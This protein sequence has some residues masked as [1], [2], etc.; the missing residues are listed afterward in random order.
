MNPSNCIQDTRHK[1]QVS[2]R[3]CATD[4]RPGQGMGGFPTARTSLVRS[5]QLSWR[6]EEH[7]ILPCAWDT[8]CGPRKFG[9]AGLI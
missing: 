5:G 1:T 2:R 6:L 4:S 8:H 3:F 7:S 9:R